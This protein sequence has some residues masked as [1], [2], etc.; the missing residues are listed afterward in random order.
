[1]PQGTLARLLWAVGAAGHTSEGREASAQREASRAMQ[2]MF[3]IL[4]LIAY[5]CLAG[6]I[7]VFAGSDGRLADSMADRNSTAALAMCGLAAGVIA[8][9]MGR[10]MS[11]RR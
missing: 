9:G 11:R 1:M 4:T 7:I 8:W 2:W 5:G 3:W 10:W 6:A